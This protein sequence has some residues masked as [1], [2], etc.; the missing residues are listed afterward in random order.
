[1]MKEKD[2]SKETAFEL[3]L[4]LKFSNILERHLADTSCV[5]GRIKKVFVDF[6]EQNYRDSAAASKKLDYIIESVQQF[7]ELLRDAVMDYYN[8]A[9]F[10]PP[11]DGANMFISNDDNIL[12]TVTAIVF[13]DHTFYNCLFNLISY[14]FR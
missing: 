2:V 10:A 7:L 13:R 1:M 8:L 3:E 11:N 5:L 12:S 6:F 9:T 14:E 4:F